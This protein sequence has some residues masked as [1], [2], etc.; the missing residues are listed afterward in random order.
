MACSQIPETGLLKPALA[1]KAVSGRYRNETRSSNAPTA[2]YHE[3]R[4]LTAFVI[5]EASRDSGSLA[6]SVS[7]CLLQPLIPGR[8]SVYPLLQPFAT[9]R[10]GSQLLPTRKALADGQDR[11][12]DDRVDPLFDLPLVSQKG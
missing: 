7:V 5:T 11:V 6:V 4:S 12:D 10:G 2:V 8:F 9:A 3:R 1:I